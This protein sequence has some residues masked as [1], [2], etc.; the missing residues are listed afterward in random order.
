DYLDSLDGK[1]I[2]QKENPEARRIEAIARSFLDGLAVWLREIVRPQNEQSPTTVAHEKA[3]MQ[4]LAGFW[5]K[6]V[7]HPLLAG[8]LNMAQLTLA[9]ALGM[10][11]RSAELDWRTGHPKLGA[12]YDRF[13]ARPSFVATAPPQ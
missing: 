10:A 1:P 9:C 13:A 11:A 3:R 5:E 2:L 8:P 12:W 7:A 6:E 4:R